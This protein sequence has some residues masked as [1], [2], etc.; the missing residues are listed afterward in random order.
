MEV[1]H[2]TP[3]Y[4]NQTSTGTPLAVVQLN[5][6]SACGSGQQ[7][8]PG[9]PHVLAASAG[10]A[11]DAAAPADAAAGCAEVLLVLWQQWAVAQGARPPV[12]QLGCYHG[13]LAGLAAHLGFIAQRPP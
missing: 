7:A 2:T 9:K 1:A 6:A 3:D 5:H 8:S 11:A 12:S 4:Y 10:A 13:V